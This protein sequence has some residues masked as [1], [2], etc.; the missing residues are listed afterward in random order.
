MARWASAWVFFGGIGL[1]FLLH[2]F[3]NSLQSREDV[4]EILRLPLLGQIPKLKKTEAAEGHVVTI[5]EPESHG[6]EAFRMVRGNLDFLVVDGSYSTLMLTSCI[7]GE[8]KTLTLCNLGVALALTGKR[9]IVVDCD[10]RRP[11]V[12]GVFG[13]SNSAGVS[14]VVSGQ[15]L[16]G[17][18]LKTV[19]VAPGAVAADGADGSPAAGAATDG[20]RLRMQVLTSG[21]KPPNPG[22][23]CASGALALLL[24]ELAKQADFVLVD[25]PAMLAVGDT[26]ALANKVDGMLFLV[27]M[28]VVKR[29]ELKEAADRLDKMPCRKLGVIVTRQ[30]HGAGYY[31][32]PYY[33][34]FDDSG[35]KVRKRAKQKA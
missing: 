32:Q 6:A 21:P 13:L 25:S 18:S 8:G 22:E 31:S 20:N 34:S 11:R 3:D 5:E 14:T 15:S 7:K 16:L 12:H 4:A 24:E 30:H 17:D 9:V 28:H 19:F 2:Q 27:D 23:I 26:A 29:S 35:A 1:A 33:Y 10:L